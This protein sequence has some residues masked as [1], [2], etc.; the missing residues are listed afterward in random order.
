MMPA[1][2]IAPPLWII[3]SGW[4]AEPDLVEAPSLEAARQ[5]AVQF[6]MAKGL[7]AEDAGDP[8]VSWAR[9]FDA[10]V[11]RDLGLMWIDE[12]HDMRAAPSPWAPSTD[13]GWRRATVK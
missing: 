7:S 1:S 13:D 2:R 10:D 3:A 5:K 6:S 11:A 12:R 9:P 4:D 8:E